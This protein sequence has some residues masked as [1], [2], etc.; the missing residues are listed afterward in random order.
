MGHSR[1]KRA[2]FWFVEWLLL[3]G[4][5]ELFVST[6]SLSEF[7]VGIFAAALAST[8]AA[9]VEGNYFARF[10]PLPSW[11]MYVFWEPYYAITGTWAILVALAKKLAGHEPD[12]KLSVVKFPAGG[13]DDRS[14]ARRALMIT[15]MT[16]PP[17]FVVI[18][19]DKKKNQVLYHQVSAT[20]VPLIAQ[21]LGARA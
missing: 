11:I 20:G 18:G 6:T 4:L 3:I 1:K 2:L 9:V 7:L 17:N 13:E 16:L 15:Y 8:A 19:I 14:A 10:A 21:K 12:S 5:W